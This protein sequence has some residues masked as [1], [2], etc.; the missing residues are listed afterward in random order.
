VNSPAEPQS[1]RGAPTRHACWFQ[2]SGRKATGVGE[3]RRTLGR[4]L[5]LWGMPEEM[6]DDAVL[7]MSELTTN[8]IAHTDS[9]DI[10][11][12]AAVTPDYCVH[13]EVHDD[14]RRALD[15]PFPGTPTLRDE[16]G[17][18][19]LLVGCIAEK[20]GMDRSVYTRGNAVWA[21]LPCSVLSPVAAL[22]A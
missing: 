13:L 15:G 3:A 4:Q 7:V 10:R 2:I 9:T 20:W 8:A 17:R 22:S 18:G 11:C 21:A 5:R 6:R 19:L 16:T 1:L 14:D 12:C